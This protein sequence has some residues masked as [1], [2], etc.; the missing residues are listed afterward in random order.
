MIKIRNLEYEGQQKDY[1]VKELAGK[2]EEKEKREKDR[3][4]EL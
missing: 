4:N 1:K 2:I 3:E